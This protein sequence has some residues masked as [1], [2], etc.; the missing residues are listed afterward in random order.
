MEEVI[1]VE[2]VRQPHNI[3]SMKT[4]PVG[5]GGMASVIGQVSS[6]RIM[7]LIDKWCKT[8]LL[9]V[10]GIDL[11]FFSI[12]TST[13]VHLH[14]WILVHREKLL[15]LGMATIKRTMP[16]AIWHGD[17][18]DHSTFLL[19][20]ANERAREIYFGKQRNMRR[21]YVLEWGIITPWLLV[22]LFNYFFI[23][24]KTN[25]WSLKVL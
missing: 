5:V 9:V 14:G 19:E 17:N 15:K 12:H 1:F 24:T 25:F 6:T 13:I 3:P 8:Y 11:L 7:Q 23:K 20:S 2:P 21:F 10:R 18:L 4:I 22:K 16:L